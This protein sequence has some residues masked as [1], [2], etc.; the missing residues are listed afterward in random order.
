MY[1]AGI[2]P[3]RNLL[4]LGLLLALAFTSRVSHAAGFQLDRFEPAAAGNWFFGVDHPWYSQARLIAAGLTFD[5][6]HNLLLGGRYTPDGSFERSAAIIEHQLVGHVDVA[7]A[8]FDRVQVSAS[9]PVVLF[10]NGTAAFGVTPL[11]TPAVGDPRI[12]AMVRLWH[13]A[14]RDPVSLHAGARLFIP[15][16]GSDKLAGDPSLRV[17]PEVIAAGMVASHVRWTGSGSLLLRGTTS[18]GFGPAS[19]IGSELQLRAGIGWTDLERRFNVGPEA[20]LSVPITGDNAFT[21]RATSFELL[22]G[23]QVSL[24]HFVQVGAA[25]GLGAVGTI[26]T[27]DVRVLVR[28]AYA[29]RPDERR[30]DSDHDG[31]PD[32]WDACPNQAGGQRARGCPDADADGIPDADDLCPDVAAGAKPDPSRKGCGVDADRDGIP[33]AED[34]CPDQPTGAHPDPSGKGRPA[35][36]RDADGVPD[37]EDLCPNQAP[38][39]HP[40]A[41]QKG[42]PLPDA[43]HDGIPD[44]DDLCPA[45]AAGASPDPKKPG[46]PLPDADHDGIP[47]A[48]DACPNL[49]G[50]PDPDPKKGG[51]PKL[52]TAAGSLTELK[53]VLFK[54]NDATLLPESFPILDEV[55][56]LLL[57]H[58]KIQDVVI[59]G[60]AD[61]TGTREWNM[62]LSHHRAESVVRYLVKKGIARRR[63]RAVGFGDTRPLSADRT[64]EARA[65]NRRVEMRIPAK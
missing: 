11:A 64:E 56:K 43:D 10:E 62:R 37:A 49:A 45:A 58:P 60:N 42:C 59:E 52:D 16:G 35:K 4:A 8:F 57:A 22:A 1:D 12:G 14:E 65:K 38:G 48:L 15:T 40:D 30:I 29:P 36:D 13:H 34:L 44:A 7:A 39:T 23:G 53:S 33:D 24:F 50:L 54:T 5:Y 55:V 46:C 51:C 19:S 25:I 2:K 20:T 21:R 28:I 63:L 17:M 61:D 41:R 18:L 9:L 27:P 32:A 26:G 47:D 3:T 6:G 31:V